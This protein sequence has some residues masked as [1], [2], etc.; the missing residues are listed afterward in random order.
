MKGPVAQRYP[1]NFSMNIGLG[2]VKRGPEGAAYIDTNVSEHAQLW[3]YRAWAEW[4][5]A[6]N[7]ADLRQIHSPAPEAGAVL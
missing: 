5:D 7:W 4:M 1:V 3:T 6:E 2:Q